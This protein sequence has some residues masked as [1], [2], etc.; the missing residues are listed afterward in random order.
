MP[1][2]DIVGCFHPGSSRA[3]G[4]DFVASRATVRIWK[5]EGK[6]YFVSHGKFFQLVAVIIDKV[7]D[8]LG[9][10]NL[11]PFS[12]TQKRIGDLHL[13]PASINYP[14]PAVADHRLRWQSRFMN[15]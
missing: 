5:D 10:G 1:K 7:S 6:G 11:V 4:P 8:W 15:A 12:R 9:R 3:D 14:I 13:R 2:D